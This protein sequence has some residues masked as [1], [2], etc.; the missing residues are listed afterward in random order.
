MKSLRQSIPLIAILFSASQAL[1]QESYV[2]VEAH[3]GKVLLE[4]NADAKRPVASL[5]KVATAMVILDWSKASGTSM[6]SYATVPN[7]AAALGGSNPMGLAP[8][9]QIT[10]REAMYSMLLGSDNVSAYT[11]A[12]HAGRSIMARGTTARTPV[13][14]F[15]KEM[16]NLARAIGMKRTKFAN[17][18]GM[19]TARQ[20]GS[21]TARDMA[22][23][24]IY[25]MRNTGFQYYVKQKTRTIASSRFGQKRAFK[26][27]NTHNLIGQMGINGI[28]TGTTVLAGPCIAT[29]AEKPNIVQKLADGRTRLTPRRLIVV[30]LGSPDRD[31]R[32]LTLIQQ[33]WPRY[34][35][36][37]AQGR[38]TQNAAR[39]II[40]VPKL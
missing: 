13:A 5:T 40:S 3:S 12:D 34:D 29:S 15:V 8:G 6:G 16:N 37:T 11:L 10:L 22:A 31:G 25:A 33:S 24:S 26:V 21:S 18:H 28:K 17:P 1:A 27:K 9:D 20:R 23:L 38:T 36:W 19:D 7:E 39:E 4:L 2:S 32:T 14:S 35:A 30:C